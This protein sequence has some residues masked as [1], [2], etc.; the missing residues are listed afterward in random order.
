[1][2]GKVSF[3]WFLVPNNWNYLWVFFWFTLKNSCIM[4]EFV[5]FSSVVD[6]QVDPEEMVCWADSSFKISWVG[7]FEYSA[8]DYSE[9]SPLEPAYR[10]KP[11]QPPVKSPHW[12]HETWHPTSSPIAWVDCEIENLHEMSIIRLF[13]LFENSENCNVPIPTFSGS[14]F[15]LI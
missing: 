7:G 1:M 9:R 10:E 2:I 12:V 6:I 14:S 11:E 4:T 3:I 13:T 15:S 5:F 8:C